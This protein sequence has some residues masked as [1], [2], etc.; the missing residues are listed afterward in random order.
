[1]TEVDIKNQE[2]ATTHRQLSKELQELSAKAKSKKGTSLESHELSKGLTVFCAG[3]SY[4]NHAVMIVVGLPAYLAAEEKVIRGLHEENQFLAAQ[5]KRC[6]GG[7]H[8]RPSTAFEK[9]KNKYETKLVR[10][11]AEFL[12]GVRDC[13]RSGLRLIF[14]ARVFAMKNKLERHVAMLKLDIKKAQQGARARF[15]SLRFDEVGLH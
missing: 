4:R 11:C 7:K 10:P 12:C 14:P 3:S 5:V 15:K 2:F 9:L 1:V 6:R 13:T 8:P